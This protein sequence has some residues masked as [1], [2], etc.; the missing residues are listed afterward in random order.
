ML[1]KLTEMTQSIGG[2]LESYNNELGPYTNDATFMQLK[3]K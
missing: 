3:Q 1:K 2:L